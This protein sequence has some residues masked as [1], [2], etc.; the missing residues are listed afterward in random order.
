MLA[1]PLPLLHH[2]KLTVA[3][4]FDEGEVVRVDLPHTLTMQD[5][6]KRY[7]H[8]FR[9]AYAPL[10]PGS[11]SYFNIRFQQDFD[12]MVQMENVPSFH[13]FVLA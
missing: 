7:F 9:A 8:T 10:F 11:Q 13:N 12:K 1:L 6:I 3:K 4:L 2:S 5:T